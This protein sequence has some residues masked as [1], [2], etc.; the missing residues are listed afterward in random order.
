MN[1]VYLPH[2]TQTVKWEVQRGQQ[3]W[4]EIVPHSFVHLRS[5]KCNLPTKNILDLRKRAGA[6]YSGADLHPGQPVLQP[7]A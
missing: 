1:K 3:V 2:W 6:Q 7:W 5:K 4:N